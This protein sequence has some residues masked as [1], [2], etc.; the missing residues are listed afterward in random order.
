[1]LIGNGVDINIVK[2]NGALAG[3]LAKEITTA[4]D[5]QEYGQ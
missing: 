5:A 1:M 4:I 3:R 2:E